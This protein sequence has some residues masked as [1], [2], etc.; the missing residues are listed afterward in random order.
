MGWGYWSLRQVPFIRKWCEGDN[1]FK[2]VVTYNGNVGI[3][4]HHCAL[5]CDIIV[6]GAIAVYVY[7]FYILVSPSLRFSVK[8]DAIQDF[9][10]A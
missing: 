7:I 5:T 1:W 9:K 3:E 2:P 6:T 8:N 4:E 10:D